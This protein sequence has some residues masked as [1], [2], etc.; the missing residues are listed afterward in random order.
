VAEHASQIQSKGERHH[1][2]SSVHAIG[3]RAKAAKTKGKQS[4]VIIMCNIQW[5]IFGFD[6]GLNLV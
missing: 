1:L 2:H 5:Y 6:F 3:S 4:R